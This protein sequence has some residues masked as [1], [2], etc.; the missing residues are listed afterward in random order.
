M[1]RKAS[2]TTATALDLRIVGEK[3]S[4][5]PY[6]S[7][8]NFQLSDKVAKGHF[9]TVYFGTNIVT[10]VKVALKRVQLTKMID[11]KAA[12][13]CKREIILL[14][15]LDHP[16]VIKYISHF[17]S[18]N[19]DLYIILE[20]ASAGDLAKMIE[21][22][23][24]KQKLL[25]EKTIWKYFSQICLGL[26]HMHSKRIMHRDIKPAN[27]FINA[28]GAVKLGDLGLGRFFPNEIDFTHSKLGTP[29]Y[30]SPERINELGLGYS[31][32]ADIWSLGCVLYEMAVFRSPF[33]EENLT[34][35]GLR[36]KIDELD[37]APLSSKLYSSE[38]RDLVSRCLT[39]EPKGRPIIA[40]VT[41]LSITM[42]NQYLNES[43]TSTTPTSA[44]SS[45]P[46]S[47]IGST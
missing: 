37:Y 16:N 29:Y 12:E 5:S 4:Q 14:Q 23:V 28:Q 38:L 44:D 3:I 34:F 45:S 1:H 33:F 32:S 27:I 13:D 7:L 18:T 19:S 40:E 2:E 20:L 42:Y 25:P 9:S 47:S 24:Q 10:G 26:E 39:L 31:F 30:M 43:F 36:K 35:L 41:Q 15:K 11:K 46:D 8:Q 21:Y 22:F 17:I 6:N